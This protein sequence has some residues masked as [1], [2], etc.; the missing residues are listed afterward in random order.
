MRTTLAALL[1]TVAMPALAQDFP[2]TIEH[3][4]GETT[5][6]EVPERV[7]SLDF[8]G[9]DN[10]LALGVQPVAIRYWYGDHPRAVWPWAEPLLEGTPEILRGELNY[11][12][13]ARSE[14]DV[15]IAIASGITEADYAHLSQIAPVVA[16][17]PGL[18][19]YE[20]PWD[21]RALLAGRIVGREEAARSQ[22]EAIR[23][24][25]AEEAA[26]HPE[27]EGLS[28]A[29][30]VAEPGGI[31]GAYTS[32]DIRPKMIADLGFEPAPVIDEIAEEG[33]FWTYISA[34]DLS[35]LDQ[36]LLFWMNGAP[37]MEPVFEVAGRPFLE[38]HREGREVY[39]GAEMFSAFSHASL[40][41][42]PFAL[43]RLVPMIEAALDGDPETHADDRPETSGD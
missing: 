23:E 26:A 21:E 39:L 28:F 9:A 27:W 5:I 30:A 13:V 18:T 12:Q 7:A 19:D 38:A 22:V 8:S 40:L 29:V 25:F 11:E 31:P 37:G 34:E 33:E 43:D 15:I 2:L 10:L 6:P 24:T 20:L 32:I 35:P 14:P 36:D 41:S 1:A 3:K 17:P 42:L 4:Y 16:V